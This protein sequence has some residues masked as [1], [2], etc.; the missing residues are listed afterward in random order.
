MVFFYKAQHE[1]KIRR[2]ADSG[3]K[4]AV[5]GKAVPFTI[6]CG[7][8][9]APAALEGAGTILRSAP[10]A[11]DF[12]C[13]VDVVQIAMYGIRPMPGKRFG[14]GFQHASVLVIVIRIQ[15][16][17]DISRSHAYPFV[18]GIINPLVRFG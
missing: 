11:Y 10:C 4:A 1:L 3:V 8:R 18:H 15:K 12:P 5:T 13:P 9:R 14:N 17:D 2:A 6:E 7:V 16:A